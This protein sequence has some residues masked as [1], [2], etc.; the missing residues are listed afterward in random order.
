MRPQAHRDA[1]RGEPQLIR[2]RILRTAASLLHTSPDSP[3][4]P[5]LTEPPA[6]SAGRR[7]PLNGWWAW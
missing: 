5:A 7:Y 4:E 1:G 6:V 2:P 3:E